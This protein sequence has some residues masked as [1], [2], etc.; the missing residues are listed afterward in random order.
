MHYKTSQG[1]FLRPKLI[2]I[3]P[4]YHDVEIIFLGLAIGEFSESIKLWILAITAGGFLYV[5]LVGMVSFM[6][7]CT[8]LFHFALHATETCNRK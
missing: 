3:N 4:H 5:G 1:I 2:I 8:V 7:L 6:K